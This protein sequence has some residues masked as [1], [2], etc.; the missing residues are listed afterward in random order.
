MTTIR[1]YQV[2]DWV[3][4]EQRRTVTPTTTVA[5]PHLMSCLAN[6]CTYECKPQMDPKKQLN[7]RDEA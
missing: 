7:R 6:E 4:C 1:W 3:R 2:I 5:C